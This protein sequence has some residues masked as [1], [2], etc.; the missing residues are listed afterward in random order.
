LNQQFKTLAD[1][2]DIISDLEK[3]VARP[4][5]HLSH[6]TLYRK[7][8]T[9]AGDRIIKGVR[10]KDWFFSEDEKWIK[11]HDQM[12]LSFSSSFSNLKGVYKQKKKHNQGKKVDV[13]WILEAA[14]LPADMAFVKDKR[15]SGH[16]YLTVTK[17]MTVP[18]LVKK[19]KKI[20]R[21]MTKIK[22]GGEYL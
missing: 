20:A 1:L 22:E 17:D 10:V 3:I 9:A 2:K 13:Y 15:K 16:Y 12:G 11:A 14:D 7:R 6:P 19:L 21:D 18:D 4:T 8:D 5:L